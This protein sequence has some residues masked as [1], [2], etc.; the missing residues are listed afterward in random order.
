MSETDTTKLYSRSTPVTGSGAARGPT[1]TPKVK[2]IHLH[3]DRVDPELVLQRGDFVLKDP[4]TLTMADLNGRP[5]QMTICRPIGN[6]PGL[7][8]VKDYVM[9]PSHDVPTFL[10]NIKNP[11]EAQIEQKFNTGLMDLYLKKGLLRK[12]SSGQIVYPSSGRVRNDVLSDARQKA[13]ATNKERKK[14]HFER[15]EK[16]HDRLP[17]GKKKDKAK[18]NQLPAKPYTGPLATALDYLTDPKE[19]DTEDKIFAFRNSDDADLAV[20]YK[21]K[22]TLL[23]K[24]EV[25]GGADG[26]SKQAP[27]PILHGVEPKKVIQTLFKALKNPLTSVTVQPETGAAGGTDK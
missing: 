15:E 17:P 6:V 1:Q 10:I 7:D 21:E 5:V 3:L 12:D 2:K 25:L 14:A 22:E 26:T 16:E 18:P 23:A 11:N 24:Y 27:V 13:D 20:L 4:V 19:K 8:S 9:I